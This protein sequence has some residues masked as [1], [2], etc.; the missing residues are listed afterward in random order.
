MDNEK[1]KSNN[2]TKYPK[3]R[4]Y[5]QA[6]GLTNSLP[7]FLRK[8]FKKRKKS[9]NYESPN[10]PKLIKEEKKP[11]KDNDQIKI[12]KN[13]SEIN[14]NNEILANIK[15]NNQSIAYISSHNDQ[16]Y[17]K[18]LYLDNI[19]I[20][21]KI[22]FNLVQI[23]PDGNCLYHCI[24]YHI[25]GT[26]EY[27]REIRLKTYNFIKKNPTFIY[28]YCYVE[29]D[30]YYIDIEIGPERK[31]IKYF[32]EDYIE[33]IKKEGFF[34][35]FIE[36]YTL[37]KIYDT[38]LI[39]LTK[40]GEDSNFK[41]LMAYNNSSK[42]EYNIDNVIFLYFINDDH[43]HYL[44]P[45]KRF[46]KN[47]IIG[48][49]KEEHNEI[50]FE[51]EENDLKSNIKNNTNL[52]EKENRL[53][54]YKGNDIG[55]KEKADR[56]I[57]LNYKIEKTGD[58]N[59]RID[60]IQNNKALN[61][62]NINQFKGTDIKENL[63]K[64]SEKA[65]DN[66]SNTDIEDD[67]IENGIP[68]DINIHKKYCDYLKNKTLY[69]KENEKNLIEIPKF[70][71]LIGDKIITDYYVNVFKYLYSKK[72][73]NQNIK[74]YPTNITDIKDKISKNKKKKYF[75]LHAKTFYLNDENK[76][77][78]KVRFNK[79]LKY[80][81]KIDKIRENKKEYVLLKIPE[82]LDIIEYLNNL[83]KED[84]HRGIKSLRNY[85]LER[86]YYIE[87]STFLINY[88][89]K[90]CITCIGKASR[91]KLKREPTKQIITYYPKQRYVMD[92]TEVPD[93]L[94]SDTRKYLFCIID[95][96]SK[97]GMAF[98]INNKEATTILK[99]LKI[100]LEAN[101]FPEEIGSDNGK[102]FKNKLIENYLEEN[103]I[104]FIH[105][106]PYNPHSQG[107]VERFH[108]TIKD[109]LYSIYQDEKNMELKECLD[110]A[111]KKYNNHLHSATMYKPNEVF[112]ANS[113][114]LFDEVLNNIKKSFKYIGEEFKNFKLNE[115]CLLNG[116]FKI[117]KLFKNKKEGIIIFDRIKYKKIYAKIN[118][119]IRELKNNTYKIEIAKN[120]PDLN[121][122]ENDLYIVNYKL[123]F[124][125]SNETWEK[126]LNKDNE[127]LDEEDIFDNNNFI[128]EN[129]E[130]FI[131]TNNNEYN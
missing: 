58:N 66:K 48:Q 51:K 116:K 131:L 77:Y 83:H 107:V 20:Y 72:I 29:N 102:E 62:K 12:G 9:A 17:L 3:K 95:H 60:N 119:I 105:G 33:S 74:R 15:Q 57:D 22:Y 67:V 27:D 21:E 63:T 68:F 30:L 108:Q 99:Y 93:E 55:K 64:K 100:A 82:T 32:I 113:E 6:F 2:K 130:E 35:G 56:N 89:L 8:K 120:Y 47:N 7:T 88:I 16:I 24:S 97:Y 96:F 117:Q 25:Y 126:N 69:V 5:N 40:E 44:E 53:A 124:K 92:I 73:N 61:N 49:K 81:F 75:R 36:L 28:E 54:I 98:I 101:G 50:I 128:N 79:N 129:E 42:L 4:N 23:I 127:I 45:N 109:L 18:K 84:N 39:I 78:K 70:P 38:P 106:A 65:L 125:C 13:I 80:D 11:L 115:K 76:L 34:G 19:T 121:L 86:G 52:N 122:F 87:G 26:Q 85:L 14:E 103:N 71:I 111:L 59:I 91:T 114:D 43:Y 46:I 10:S 37:S 90:N 1:G 104:K 31:K 118:A 110:I 94:I 123:L 112:Y 41:K